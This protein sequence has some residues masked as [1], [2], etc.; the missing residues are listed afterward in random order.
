VFWEFLLT[1]DATNSG[2]CRFWRSM[3]RH[4]RHEAGYRGTFGAFAYIGRRGLRRYNANPS[5]PK[6]HIAKLI[7]SGAG[8]KSRSPTKLSPV[9]PTA[10]SSPVTGLMV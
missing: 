10:V 2:R 1:E 5:N 7:G 3:Q 9:L 6:P 8:W 4:V